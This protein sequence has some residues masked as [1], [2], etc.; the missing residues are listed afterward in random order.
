MFEKAWRLYV[1]GKITEAEKELIKTLEV[2]PDDPRALYLLGTIHVIRGDHAVG[3]QLL[4]RTVQIAPE[5]F[6]AWNN[7]GN[8]YKALN[9]DVQAQVCWQR[10]LAI[11]GRAQN[12]YAD[13]L[14]NIAT[15]YVN[16]GE[17]DTGIQYCKEAIKLDPQHADAHWN[18]ALLMLEKGM[19]K[20]GWELYKW[21]FRNNIRLMRNYGDIPYWKGQKDAVVAV[22]GEQ[23]IGDEI[24]FA[25]M[26][27]DLKKISRKVIFDCHPRLERLFKASFPDVVVYGTR[28]DNYITWPSQ[29]PDIQYR[30]A[31][32]D[33]GQYFRNS[34][35]D[36]P[37]HHGYLRVL[38]ED[39][40]RMRQ[41]LEDIAEG[42]SIIGIS[43]QGGTRKT[44]KDYRSIPLEKWLPIL[45]HDMLFVSLQ[46]TED[47]HK[48]IARLEE[49]YGIRIIHW[50]HILQA[51]DY[52]ETAVLV[53]AMDLVITVNTAVHHLAGALGV[54]TYT[55]T[56]VAKAWRYWIP[57]GIDRT[58]WYPSVRIF[59]QKEHLKWDEVIEEVAKCIQLYERGHVNEGELCHVG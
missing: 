32:G 41:K 36:F 58:P 10:A 7:L 14:N 57:E 30:V 31:I 28:K 29:H 18:L 38:D 19:F 13:I 12:E 39:R 22:W 11:P 6:E 40:Q 23:G 2:N 37:E 5:M 47:A 52:Y 59:Q 4:L 50:P 54:P 1:Q 33:L 49:Q 21:G 8:A 53:S 46:Y 17:P 34:L 51:E 55:L 27:P 3:I 44:R 9:L 43:W 26:I 56:P 45:K 48:E 35:D 16:A 15:L 42:R 24:L 20:E 25:S